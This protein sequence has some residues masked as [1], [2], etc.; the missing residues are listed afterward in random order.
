MLVARKVQENRCNG[1]TNIVWNSNLSQLQIKSFCKLPK[2]ASNLLE[3]AM[4]QL[5]L[6]ARSY[7]RILKVSRTIADLEGSNDILSNHIAE[8]LHYRCLDRGALI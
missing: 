4:T 8:A 7:H 2:D 3:D 1:S 6:S 5:N